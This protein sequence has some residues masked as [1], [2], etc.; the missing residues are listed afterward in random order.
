MPQNNVLENYSDLG[1]EIKAKPD[2]SD[3][4]VEVT[5][6]IGEIKKA[7]PATFIDT[8]KTF[9]TD[10]EKDIAKAQNVYALSEVTGLN[11][12]DTFNNYDLLRRSSK[13]TGMTPDLESREYTAIALTPFIAAGAIANP[14]GTA[15]G[16]LAYSA[17]DKAFPSEKIVSG[18]EKGI[19][20]ELSSSAKTTI[21]L[22][23]FLGKGMIVGGVF[24]KAPKLAEGFIKN[25]LVEYNM[26]KDLTF[27]KEQVRDIFQTG[28]L[29]TADEQSLFGSLNLT[30]P[31]LRVALQE[32]VKI[33]VPPEKLVSLVD[34]PIWAKIKSVFG[35]ESNPEVLKTTA[36]QPTKAVS[37]LIEGQVTPEVPI[38]TPKEAQ[39]AII[40]SE[41][42]QTTINQPTEGK[43]PLIQGEGQTK[44]R[45]L[46]KGVE[47]K[48]IQNKLTDTFGSLPEYQTVNMKDQA[49]K[50]QDFLIKD[51]EKAKR[52]AMGQELAPQD[53]LPESLFVAV[54]NK[55]VKEGDVNTLRDL[56][57]SSG[58][59]AEATTMGQRLRT[60]AERS[61]D[62][63]VTA[64]KEV[65]KA[66]EQRIGKESKKLHKS[67]I[68]SIREHIKKVA[69]TKEDWTSFIRSIQC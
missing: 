61:P 59:T 38:L 49:T 53:I 30:G 56:A 29:T 20:G 9:F 17:L 54:E 37:G 11:L 63:P 43:L 55:A 69:P 6:N 51:P 25:K 27:S 33:S 7:P 21:D 28:K 48:A 66:R 52:I 23:D 31:E 57:T 46:A 45:G 13:V 16:L 35:M 26:S 44:T 18:I 67:E 60:L 3:L 12:K 42:S 50:A 47:A 10:P 36:G 65:S 1:V 22:L 14:V 41:I 58:L 8:L 62:S 32:G 15:A 34:K 5:P 2:Y 68:S 19:G 4:G 24:E 39:P 40:P 64:I